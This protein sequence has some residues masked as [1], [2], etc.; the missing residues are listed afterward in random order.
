MFLE[1]C[2][3]GWLEYLGNQGKSEHTRSGYQR[4][5]RHF[6]RWY[7]RSGGQESVDPVA[8]T[9]RDVRE[10]MSFQQVVEGAK[11]ATVNQRLAALSGFYRWAL[12]R[13]LVDRN[14]ASGISSLRRDPR[15]PKALDQRDFRRLRR[16]V[17]GSGN[18]RDVA[19]FEVM[20][21]AGLRVSE[22]LA[23]CVGDVTINERSGKVVVRKGKGRVY[24]EVPL[25]REVRLALRAYLDNHQDL[26]DA[27]PL[28]VGQRGSLEDP[29]AVNRMLEKYARQAGVDGVTPHV[30][31]HS[32]ATAY[33]RSN[34]G[35]IRHLAAI[36]GHADIKT[37][38][39]YTEPG[40]DELARRM[41]RAELGGFD[42]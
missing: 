6:A 35:D 30:L 3:G 20:A 12:Q 5:L 34:P 19:L 22:A 16:A 28:W 7:K 39:V 10:W 31:R 11:P 15:R 37:T 21:G 40:F 42:G 41:D 2:M 24:R 33:L 13:E 38:M 9:G 29:S 18:L 23:L 26:D 1:N 8:V 27:D 14:P 36:L 4:G 32:F 25:T 17:H